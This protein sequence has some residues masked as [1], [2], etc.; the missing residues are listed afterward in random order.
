M[1]GER[2]CLDGIPVLAGERVDGLLLDALLALRQSLVPARTRQMEVRE[3]SS[4]D[5]YRVRREQ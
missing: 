3:L 2:S 5:S 1:D 4:L